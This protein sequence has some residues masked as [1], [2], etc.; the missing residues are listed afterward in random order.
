MYTY[1]LILYTAAVDSRHNSYM[2]L[3]TNIG[4]LGQRQ[5]NRWVGRYYIDHGE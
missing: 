1:V 3:F 5:P 2:I 4:I